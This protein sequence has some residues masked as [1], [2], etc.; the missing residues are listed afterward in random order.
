[1]AIAPIFM[2]PAVVHAQPGEV[3][4]TSGSTGC[5]ASP[6]TLVALQGNNLS[7][8]VNIQSSDPL[9][10]FDIQIATDPTVLNPV[11]FSLSG[12]ILPTLTTSVLLECLNGIVVTGNSC[13]AQDGPGVLHFSA[14]TTG[15]AVAGSGLLFTA[16]F[17]VIATTGSSPIGFNTGCANTSVP[18]T[19]VT[20]SNG[21]V[22][23]G[24]VPE[25]AQ[26]GATFGNVVVYTMASTPSSLQ[27]VSSGSSTITLTSQG[28]FNEAVD[29]T[30][31][32]TPALTTSIT[33]NGC[34]PTQTGATACDVVP[35]GGNVNSTLTVSGA[36]GN[37]T[38]TVS[39]L[40]ESSFTAVS[41]NVPVQITP[42][43]FALSS[44]PSTINVAP[45]STGTSTINVGSIS[46]FSG[47]VGLTATS[48][49]ALL[50]ASILPS[51]VSAPGSAT[52]SVFSTT[53]GT[54]MVTVA[55]MSGSQS[56]SITVPVNV[57]TPDF[58]VFANPNAL[59]V[60]LTSDG[61]AAIV[62]QS[63]NNFAGTVNLN[64]V[65][66]AV[67][68]H[69]DPYYGLTGDT[70]LTAILSQNSLVVTAG[71]VATTTIS[72]PTH[73]GQANG[74][75]TVTITAKSGSITHIGQLN[76]TLGDFVDFLCP[77]DNPTCTSTATSVVAPNAL[78]FDS[79]A[80][81]GATSYFELGT[82]IL[83]SFVLSTNVPLTSTGH[84]RTLCLLPVFYPNGTPVPL[85]VM[86]NGT[87]P[88]VVAQPH[89]RGVPG[90][91]ENPDQLCIV[92]GEG[93]TNFPGCGDDFTRV[94][95]Y[96][97]AAAPGTYTV[98]VSGTGLPIEHTQM[99]PMIVP[100]PPT[101]NQFRWIHKFSLSKNG[102]T[103]TFNA[104]VTNLD[105][106]ATIY[107]EVVVTGVGSRGDTFSL[108]S[109]ILT[110][111]PGH[112][113]NN[114]PL[115]VTFNSTF[116]GE[117]FTF[118]AEILYSGSPA[119]FSEPLRHFS[120]GIRTISIST[121]TTATTSGSFTVLA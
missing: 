115:T 69:S 86:A 9:N 16:I 121:A 72:I 55:G 43:T 97:G 80:L 78:F 27:I 48:S 30:V 58:S 109:G 116:I 83:C 84:L 102:N 46:G 119:I 22:G 101:A 45:G 53:V 35:F 61:T 47:T 118:Q 60:P 63:I 34:T 41:L 20:I 107:A 49:S 42:A 105:S 25:T 2:L 95:F 40:S 38:V 1:M 114:N 32:S 77:L 113:S 15:A 10:G 71:G 85:S 37:Y 64:A 57:L 8:A 92:F 6:P 96:A 36:T 39:G 67:D 14:T 33:S 54:Y 23:S 4:L 26:S 51:S 17:N 50:T 5:P 76:V 99:L 91:F 11:G 87:G 65:A 19:C 31:T 100:V 82:T 104:G 28:G 7:V 103:Q 52:L 62:V 21:V 12:S 98:Q 56:H 88:M 73:F 44:F 81:G 106:S 13:A 79:H 66:V 75:Y 94:Y 111:A 24:A 18:S 117:T 70:T 74:N 108:T 112:A 90:V 29:L 89:F 120:A 93:A 68:N 110:I 3:C 59:L